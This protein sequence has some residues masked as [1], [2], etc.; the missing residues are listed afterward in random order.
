MPV[1]GSF[2]LQLHG[3][4]DLARSSEL[5][6]LLD[7]FAGTDARKAVIDLSEVTFCDS[8]GVSFLVRM[9]SIA[10]HRDGDVTLI[11]APGAVQN[12]L[13]ITNLSD[14]FRYEDRMF[15][16]PSQRRQTG[17]FRPCAGTGRVERAEGAADGEEE[18]EE[19]ERRQDGFR[20]N[21]RFQA[22]QARLV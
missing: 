15:C 21:G 17:S 7:D 8:Q 6:T 12:L 11:N 10:R 2:L 1:N 22:Q 9:H 5:A 16:P 4:I 20:R 13:R 14:R 19:E 18:A 3:E